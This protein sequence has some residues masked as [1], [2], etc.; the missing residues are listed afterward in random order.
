MRISV[1]R[2]ALVIAFGTTGVA[3]VL[4]ACGFPSPLLYDELALPEA[5]GS[6][7]DVTTADVT[8]A[9]VEDLSDVPYIDAGKPGITVQ[10]AG[11]KIDASACPANA[12]DCDKDGYFDLSKKGC[13]DA[14]GKTDCDDFDSRAHPGQGFLNDPA[15]PPMNGDW[16]CNGLIEKS[17]PRTNITCALLLADCTEGFVGTPPCGEEADYLYCNSPLG[18]LLCAPKAKSRETQ[19]CK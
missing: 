8:D 7:A 3:A 11:A 16:N 2:F 9:M 14:G 4:L 5:D 13:E 15:E 18:L 6:F 1:R 19:S 10:D 17:F 12:C